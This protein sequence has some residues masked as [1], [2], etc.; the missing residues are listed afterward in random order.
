MKKLLVSAL[1]IVGLVACSQEQ[2]LVSKSPASMEF[3]VASLDKAT[4][5]DPSLT[6]DNLTGFNVWAWMDDESGNVLT[7]EDVERKGE[8]WGYFNTAYWLPGHNYSFA[9]VAPMDSAN[10]NYNLSGADNGEDNT[11]DFTNIDGTEDLIYAFATRSTVGDAVGKDYEAVELRFN[12]LLSKTKFT[13]TN[14]YATSNNTVQVRDVQ[15]EAYNAATY[16][17]KDAAWG[18][19]AGEKITLQ[20]GDTEVMAAG[21][22]CEVADE[23]LVIPTA[24]TVSYKV[25]YTIDVWQGARKA[26]DGLVKTAVVENVAFEQGKAYNFTATISPETLGLDAIEFTV[27]VNEWDEAG[28][29]EVPAADYVYDATANAYVVYTAEGFNYI[30]KD[31]NSGVIAGNATIILAND[32]DFAEV[33]T[34]AIETNCTPLGNEDYPFEGTFDGRGFAIKNFNYVADE[35]VYFVGLFGCAQNATLK[36]FVVENAYVEFASEA[37]GVGGTIGV[38]V[39]GLYGNSTLE[40]ITVKGDVKVVGELDKKGAGRIGAVVGG[41]QG[42]NNVVVKNVRVEANAGSFVQGNNAVGGISGQLQGVAT[43]VD[44]YSNIEVKAGQYFAGGIEGLSAEK[45]TFTNCH[46]AGNVSVVAG[47]AGNAN[48]LYRVGGIVGG[49]ADGKGKTLVITDC[50]FTGVIAGQDAA[51]AVAETLDCAGYVG[52]GYA[53]AV[54]SK[55][56]VNGVVYEYQGNGVY[57]TDGTFVS[58]KDELTAA[59]NDSSIA[60]IVL[61]KGEYG[62]I[63]AKSNKTISALAGAKVDAVNLNGAANVTLKNIVFDAA[64]A[65]VAVDGKGNGKQYA[66]IATGVNG[67]NANKGARNLVIDGCTF[68]G[69]FANGGASIAFTDQNRGSGQ[70][71]DITIKNCVFNTENAYYSIYAHYSG[72][73]SFVIE[74]NTFNT[75]FAQGGT[76]YLGRYQ[77]STPVVVKGNAFNKDASL[78]EAMYIQA[79]SASYN[80]SIAAENNTFAN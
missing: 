40:N 58:T 69:T 28:D 67:A 74:N 15:V 78:D 16:S 51:G 13:F 10:W 54:G 42:T 37:D 35:P 56:S 79:H 1:A 46:S 65:V 68:T 43:F 2:T 14:G 63:V 59:L 31:I 77:S 6:T 44:C 21:A 17:I 47:R 25:T 60:T 19:V 39:G 34:R 72:Y 20:Y 33:A 45:T 48:D 55:V 52:R 27:V 18:E 4:R 62:V 32:I 9:A 75:E 26:I 41:N 64:T 38:V 29:V 49:W 24:A 8:G 11:I 76:I 50:T 3:G 30:T 23:R 73:G 5:V 7:A 80:V 61:A 36:N 70:S 12:H 53:V 57:S 71:G 22:K 66:N